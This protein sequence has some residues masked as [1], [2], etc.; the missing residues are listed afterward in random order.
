[1]T[2]P[3]KDTCL[4][5]QSNDEDSVDQFVRN[6]PLFKEK[7]VAHYEIIPISV[8]SKRSIEDLHKSFAY[9]PM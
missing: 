3:Y 8:T 4:F 7:L 2:F 5:V 9:K 1:M 6:D